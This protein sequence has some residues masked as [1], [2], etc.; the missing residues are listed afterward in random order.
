MPIRKLPS[1]LVDQLAA[2]QVVERPASVVTELLENSL[3]AGSR[4]ID[5]YVENGAARSIRNLDDGH[6]LAAAQ[7]V[8]AV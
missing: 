8:L 5:I 3:D 7:P 1:A 4:H 6:G 2:G